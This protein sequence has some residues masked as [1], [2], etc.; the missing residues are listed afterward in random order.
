MS[1]RPLVMVA[2]A[3]LL[4]PGLISCGG[5]GSGDGPVTT[6][7]GAFERGNPG[8]EDLLD[9]WN[10]PDRLRSALD[11]T[12][13]ANEPARRAAISSLLAGGNVAGAG[14]NVA[15]DGTKLRNIRAED[16]EIIGERDG[17][18]YGRWKGGPAGTLN[19]EFDWGFTE[20]VDAAARARMERAGKSWSHRLMD[21]NR[22]Y[23]AP[24]GTTIEHQGHEVGIVGVE[25]TLNET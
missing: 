13:V 16:I 21:K 24:S 3:A 11:L 7:T 10:D 22:D 4:A 5:G 12:A 17:I 25:R 20:N 15:G 19:I 14:G 9:H 6:Q 1:F 18:T 2:V 23:E 8:A